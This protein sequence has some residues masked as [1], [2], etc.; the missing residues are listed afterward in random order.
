MAEQDGPM[1][2]HQASAPEQGYHEV[3]KVPNVAEQ[4]MLDQEPLEQMLND[5]INLHQTSSTEQGNHELAKVP[6]SAA[7]Q[8]MLDLDEQTDLRIFIYLSEAGSHEAAKTSSQHDVATAEDQ[9]VSRQAL[10][11]I[12]QFIRSILSRNPDVST[13]P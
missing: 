2:L 9:Q 8:E 12:R 6:N 5:Q 3:A 4:E 11:R 13:R 1:N 7:Q 10:A